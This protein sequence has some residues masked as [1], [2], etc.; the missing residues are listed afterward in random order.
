MKQP[1]LWS[2]ELD[3]RRSVLRVILL[4]VIA[5]CTFAAFANFRAGNTLFASIELTLVAFSGA[6]LAIHN[7]TRR[8]N[9]WSALFLL[10]CFNTVIAGVYLLPIRA[11]LYNWMGVVLVLSYLLLGLRLGGIFAVS[12]MLLATAVLFLRLS[13][14]DAGISTGIII[15]IVCCMVCITALSHVF[16]AKRADMVARLQ[17]IAAIDPLTAL[18]N[19]LHLESVF[20]QLAKGQRGQTP[21]LAMILIDLDHFKAINDRYGHSA[22]DAVLTH[23]ARLMM[24][25]CRSGDWAFRCGGEEFCLLIPGIEREQ[26]MQ[27]AERLRLNIEQAT[28]QATPHTLRVTASLGVA[29]WPADGSDLKALYQVVDRRLYDAKDAGRN[30]V[31]GA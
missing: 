3:F 4:I 20:L 25:A 2:D 14:Q 7:T 16:E 29:H 10:A 5:F 22:G 15:N 26:A 28:I 17:N 24:E 30:R 21:G 12:Y 27:I 1:Q 6:L 19:R 13:R 31:I 18:H 8:L 23:A 9:V 11:A